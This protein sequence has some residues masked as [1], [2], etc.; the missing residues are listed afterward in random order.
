MPRQTFKG[1]SSSPTCQKPPSKAYGQIDILLLHPE[2]VAPTMANI[3]VGDTVFVPGDMHGMVKFIGSVAGKRGTFAGVQLATEYAGRGKNSGEVEGKSYFRTT[4]PGAGIF[5]PLEKAIKKPASSGRGGSAGLGVGGV[6]A[7]PGP[8]TPGNR[9]ASFNQGG[10][11]PGTGM[12][13]PGFSQSVGPGAMRPPGAASPALK[14]PI[15]RESLP[16]PSSPLR[17]V[18]TPTPRGLA[19]PK[20]RPSGIGL[21]KSTNG[22]A[23]GR[24]YTRPGQRG[25]FTQ[26]LRQGSSMSI[27]S[28]SLG[29][30][31]SFDEIPENEE[32]TPTPTPNYSRKPTADVDTGKYETQIRGLNEELADARRQLHDQSTNIAEME[33]NFNELQKLLPDLEQGKRG[34]KDDDDDDEDL[35]HE[36]TTLRD[37]LREKNDKIR[38]LTAKFDANRADFRSTIDTLEMASTETE[39]VYE[40]R[41][42]ELLEEVRNLQDRSEDVETVAQQLKQ[43]EELVQELEEGL[44]DARRGE[45][46]ARGEV[47]FLRGEVER[48]RSELRRERERMK[49]EEQLNGGGYSSPS[50]LHDLESQLTSKDDEIRGLKV[51]I[52][53]LNASSPKRPNGVL[54]MNGGHQRKESAVADDALQRQIHDLEQLLQQKSAH[55]EELAQ[56]VKQLRNSVTLSKFP[57]PGAAFGLHTAIRSP[58]A[59]GN[60]DELDR[61]HLSTGTVA[62]QRTVVLGAKSNGG[63]THARKDSQQIGQE[64]WHDALSR[65]SSP[66]PVKHYEEKERSEDGVTDISAAESSVLWCE[67]CEEGGHD[68]L[69]CSNM[70][71]S[72]KKTGD[73][74]DSSPRKTG[75]DVVKE[76]LRR[77]VGYE[78]EKRS[79]ATLDPDRPAPLVSRKSTNNTNSSPVNSGHECPNP[80]PEEDLPLPPIPHQNSNDYRTDSPGP[81]VDDFITSSAPSQSGPAKLIEGTGAQA[82]MLA[83]RSTGTI[84]PEKW[85]A[86]CERDGHDSVDCPVE[87]AF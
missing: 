21:A 45:A 71:G 74:N 7:S 36:V 63:N 31:S 8:G 85:C 58:H 18:N 47:E 66:S 52:Q 83:G 40:K 72:G 80:P 32:S 37:V 9:L 69:T 25:N 87:D 60:S 81:I 5:L 39:R 38:D 86:L 57:M 16:R 59:R 77:S 44:E 33:H 15:R 1:L 82:G 12:A 54:T 79:L 53:S 48:S 64:S 24:P 70:F 35:P 14:P 46:E 56:G 68:I 65:E 29:P 41:V 78:D 34:R 10:R 27:A 67:I 11:T 2:N 17:K 55:E 22:G 13:K 61:K 50:D 42:D 4:I 51:I 20:S 49:T 19:T 3:N 6:R 76:G 23:M 62:S 28:P 84:D 43:L 26:S 30:E 75:R 73:S